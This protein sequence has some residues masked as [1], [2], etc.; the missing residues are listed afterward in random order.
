MVHDSIGKALE[1]VRDFNLPTDLA[2]SVHDAASQAFVSGM[3]VAAWVGA[4]VVVC[5]AVIA[6]RFLPARAERVVR[7][8]PELEIEARELAITDDGILA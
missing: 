5:A 2:G 8:D 1:A 7:N 6:Y 4:A 3:Q